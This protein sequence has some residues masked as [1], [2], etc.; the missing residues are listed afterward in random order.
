MTPNPAYIQAVKE[1][2]RRSPYPQLI[3]MTIDE[4]QI[5][6]CVIGLEL[7]E[8][9]LQ[10]FGVVH[11]GVLATL[12][13][14]ATFWAAF[15]RLPEDAGLV[16]VDLKLNYLKATTRGHLRAEGRCLRAGRQ[17][18]YA[19]AHVFDEAGELVTHGTSTLM[20]LPGKGLRLEVAKFLSD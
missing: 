12:I 13:D 5:D 15:L 9:H 20:A 1:S 10:P 14:T 18:S 3:G 4:L 17:I 8:R 2:V 19:E 6:S 7:A 16:N 11:G